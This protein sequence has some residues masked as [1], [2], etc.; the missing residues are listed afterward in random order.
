MEAR[1]KNA[2]LYRRH[3]R[4]VESVV[5]PSEPANF[6]HVYNQFTIR[7]PDRDQLFEFLKQRGI[8][9]MVYYPLSLH[10]QKAFSRLGYK[11]GDFPESEKAQ[12]EVLS[13]PIYP[14]LTEPEI[15]EVCLAI[16]KYYQ[17]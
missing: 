14:E 5:L 15:E 16:R 13:L 10:L 8:G 9:A 1:R 2:A 3:L 7:V 4:S 11:M 6:Y 17:P 12:A